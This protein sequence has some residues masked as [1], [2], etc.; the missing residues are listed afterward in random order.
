MKEHDV[1]DILVPE[2][3]TF[4]EKKVEFGAEYCYCD[5]ADEMYETEEQIQKNDVSM[6][7]AYRKAEGLLTSFEIEEIRTKYG[8]SQFDFCTVLGWGKKTIT[9]YETHQVQDKAHDTIL[10][11][12]DNDPE[13]FITLLKDAKNA[14]PVSSYNR[15]LAYAIKIFEADQDRYLRKSIEACYAGVQDNKLYQGNSPLSI[16]KAVDVIRYF[17][18]SSKVTNLYKVKLMKL[19]WYADALSYKQRGH[20]ITGLV[21]RALPMGA[22]PI[23]HDFIIDLKGVPCEEEDIG[24]TSA[25]HFSLKENVLY[26]CLT[27]EDISILDT[28]IQKL[29]FMS[30]NEIVEYM[31]KEQAYKKTKQRD[32]ISFEYAKYLQI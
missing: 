7:D 31:H 9:R 28:V 24:E 26:P 3:I 29:G 21:Y 17:A 30:K 13:W 14:I 6:K 32:V 18:S 8:I 19:L 25:Y 15:C 4:K 2:H 16:D 5:I 20:A 1:K 12:M 23:A 10:R 27:S 22:V 11:K